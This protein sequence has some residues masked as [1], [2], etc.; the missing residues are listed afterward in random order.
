MKD[1]P[2]GYRRLDPDETMG[3]W[4][5]RARAETEARMSVALSRKVRLAPPTKTVEEGL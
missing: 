5:Y 1:T 4:L 3:R 2:V